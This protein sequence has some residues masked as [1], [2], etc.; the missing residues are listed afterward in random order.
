MRNPEVVIA[1]LVGGLFGLIPLVVQLVSTRAQ[2]RDRMTR[3]NHLRAELE[4]LERLHTLEKEVGARD[5]AAKP[6]TDLI[7]SDSLSN[8]L[9]QYNKLSEIAPSAVAGG[10]QPSP[11]QL[12]FLKRA[13]LLYTPRTTSGWILHILFYMFSVI[14]WAL[15]FVGVFVIGAE[16]GIDD[17][18]LFTG[19]FLI[20]I[21]IVLL[22]IQRRAQRIAA[23]NAA[24][25]EEPNA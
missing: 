17:F 21:G 25:L 9:D 5:E 10:K 20:P 24:Q 2:R 12:F 3:L 1:A 22:I 23:R 19:I 7:I 8:L 16:F 14:F 18:F 6:Q 13:F 11:Q 4:L 15:L